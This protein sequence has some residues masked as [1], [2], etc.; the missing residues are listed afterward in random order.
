M[1]TRV[2]LR[3]RSQVLA[4]ARRNGGAEAKANNCSVGGGVDGLPGAVHFA[5]QIAPGGLRNYR[6]SLGIHTN[7]A[8]ASLNFVS[9]FE[10]SQNITF[11]RRVSYPLLRA[12]AA[13]WVCS[14]TKTN[15]PNGGYVYNDYECTREGCFNGPGAPQTT[16]KNPAIAIAFIRRILGHLVDVSS[17]GLV[18]PPPEELAAWKDRLANLAPI[19]TGTALNRSVLLPQ[20]APV[21]T[22]PAE[23]HD[24]PLEFYAIFP[25]EQIG[26]S[27][28]PHLLQAAQNTVTMAKVTQTSRGKH[29]TLHP[30]VY[31]PP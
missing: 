20:E 6:N 29:L 21:F 22:F 8:F 12:V 3:H 13:W 16:D 23:E 31:T 2:H 14:L 25:G 11:L 27:S 19:P 18:S 9:A 7:A 30:F 10:F 24:N 4:Y 17:R 28:D 1:P 15:L 26:L 5:V